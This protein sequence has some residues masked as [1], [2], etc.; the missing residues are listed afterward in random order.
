MADVPD[1][2]DPLT[3]A[4]VD[5]IRR[6]IAEGALDDTPASLEQRPTPERGE[7]GLRS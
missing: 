2:G 5:R 4:E 7:G 3:D 6:W 1:D